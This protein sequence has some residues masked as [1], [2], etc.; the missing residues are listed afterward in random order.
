MINLFEYNKKQ[1]F[2]HVN[3]F[4]RLPDFGKAGFFFKD[5]AT[6]SLLTTKP[7]FMS[8]SVIVCHSAS[9]SPFSQKLLDN[10]IN[11]ST[12]TQQQK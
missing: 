8:S 2:L 4:Y 12:S 10:A 9:G 3:E 1:T 6:G 7:T 11:L 5:L